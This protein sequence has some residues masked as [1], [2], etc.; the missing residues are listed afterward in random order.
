MI[1]ENGEICRKERKRKSDLTGR[2]VSQSGLSVPPYL[3]Q[4][5]L[6]SEV[7]RL[8]RITFRD[9]FVIPCYFLS[10][11]LCSAFSHWAPLRPRI[12]EPRS[13]SVAPRPAETTGGMCGAER[14]FFDWNRFS[15]SYGAR[16][17]SSDLCFASSWSRAWKEEGR[18]RRRWPRRRQRNERYGKRRER[19]FSWA[20]KMSRVLRLDATPGVDLVFAD[21]CLV[22][23]KYNALSHVSMTYFYDMIKDSLALYNIDSET[24]I[25]RK[26][27]LIH[28]SIIG[29]SV[30]RQV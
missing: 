8:S 2:P 22:R 7:S 18:I 16:A 23:R 17:P 14:P 26:C 1:K 21:A 15:L 4:T 27:R 13:G 3:V 11:V 6:L 5:I 29:L 24:F 20:T 25:I 9:R 28:H 10:N 19:R 30:S 12:V